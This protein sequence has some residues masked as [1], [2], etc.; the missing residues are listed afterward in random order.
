MEASLKML[1]IIWAALLAAVVL[2]VYFCSIAKVQSTPNPLFFRAIVLVA[3]SE[4]VALFVLRRVLFR[5][6][7]ALLSS[8]PEDALSLKKWRAGNIVSWCFSL[9]IAL[10][11]V[12]LRY[13]GFSFRQAVPFFAVGFCLILLL[14]PRRPIPLR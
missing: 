10:Y 5:P 7:A 1:K 13:T 3:C 12:V 9:S 11:G 14:P 2:Y 4:V 6:A 8:Q